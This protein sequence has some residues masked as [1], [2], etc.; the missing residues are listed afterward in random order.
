MGVARAGF[1]ILKAAR[2]IA[3]LDTGRIKTPNTFAKQYLSIPRSD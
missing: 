1:R 2:T 3:G